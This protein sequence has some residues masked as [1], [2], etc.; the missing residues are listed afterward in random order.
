MKDSLPAFPADEDPF[1]PA[2]AGDGDLIAYWRAIRKRLWA[3]LLLAA[4][5]T[6]LGAAIA[7]SM[8]PLYRST[9][10]LLIDPGQQAVA[11]K[12]DAFMLDSPY[13]DNVQTQ[14]EVLKSR[15]VVMQ[16]IRGMRL[17]ERAEFDPRKPPPA[18]EAQVREW[19][20]IPTAPPVDWN[21]D[22]LAEAVY[23]A[24]LGRASTEVPPGS[25]LV[26]L[27]FETADPDLAP[28]ILNNWVRVYVEVDREARFKASRG[29]N[30]WL[31]ERAADLQQNLARAERALQSY[32]EQNNLVNVR[33]KAEAVSTTQMEGLMPQII[34]ARVKLTEVESIYRQVQTVRDGDYSSVPWIM[35]RTEVADA[36]ARVTAVKSKLA[37]LSQKY[38]FEHPIIVQAEAELAEARANLKGEMSLA[39]SSLAREY[40]NARETLG[41]LERVTAVERNKAQGVNKVEF[42]LGLLEREVQ[43]N[44]EMFDMFMTR[45][46][47]I[48]IA[49]DLDKVV[50]RVIDAAIPVYAPVKPNKPKMILAALF[51]GLFIGLV[52]ALLLDALDN[53][54]KGADDL[55]NRLHLPALA[56]LPLLAAEPGH[57]TLA[58]YQEQS[59]SIFAEA[60]R[61][62]RTGLLLSALDDPIRVF[63][64]T[65]SLPSEGKSTFASNIALALSQNKSTL[66]VEADMRRPGLAKSFGLP[67]D[68]KGLANLVSGDTLIDECIHPMEGSTLNLLPAGTLPPNPLELLSSKRFADTLAMLKERFEVI[69]IDTPPVELVSDALIV[70]SL[71]SATVFV[72][73]TADTP[74]P[75]IRKGLQKLQRVDARVLGVVLN[76]V[77]F[78]KAQR[79][80]GEYKGYGKRGYYGSYGTARTT[81]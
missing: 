72:V 62:A 35:N 50:A 75:I 55:E 1:R 3:I 52:G 23:G 49:S 12:D 27:S 46:K 64:V 6:L 14:I 25:R 51:I 53:S 39:V 76:S 21:D 63:A 5:V 32:R 60:V 58:I 73:R 2:P 33:G 10:T 56:S 48:D 69:V 71:A 68:C 16:A 44:R 41:A 66:L 24:F 36:N 65:S 70:A 7:N 59:G 22:R 61:T 42:Q 15:N 57:A 54:I 8:P 74:L 34:S 67:A 80:Y 45:A 11:R 9:T 78:D 17:W 28:V 40:E 4:V 20:G 19:L 38:G 26:R 37:Q 43:T 30:A 29:F 31:Q 18:W 81:A 77:D 47:Q 79:Y 13:G